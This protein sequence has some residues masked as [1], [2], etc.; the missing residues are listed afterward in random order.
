MEQKTPR[1]KKER[2]KEAFEGKMNLFS[3]LFSKDDK[4]TRIL[5]KHFIRFLLNNNAYFCF[6][7]NTLNPKNAQWLE[8]NIPLKNPV[9]TLESCFMWASS[10]EGR[11]F[12]IDLSVKWQEY[13]LNF[14]K[15]RKTKVSNRWS[16]LNNDLGVWYVTKNT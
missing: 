9:Y 8:F 1:L 2:I 5:V 6:V 3:L 13:A 7:K 16:R 14:N 15:A 12:W 10:P 4:E 11:S